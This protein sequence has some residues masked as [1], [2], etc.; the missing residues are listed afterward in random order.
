MGRIQTL[1]GNGTVTPADGESVAVRYQLEIWQKD[2]PSRHEEHP[3]INQTFLWCSARKADTANGRRQD[4][5]LLLH[6]WKWFRDGNRRN[7]GIGEGMA[8]R[9]VKEENIAAFADQRW[10]GDGNKHQQKTDLNGI[11]DI[12]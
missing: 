11:L 2:I 10:N 5:G 3:G 7:F 1:N 12:D 6:R 8:N 9:Q 4:G